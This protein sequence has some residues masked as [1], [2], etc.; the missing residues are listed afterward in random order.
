MQLDPPIPL[1]ESGGVH[2]WEQLSPL[3]VESFT[4]NNMGLTWLFAHSIATI[5]NF[6]A[7]LMRTRCDV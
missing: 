5:A 2:V 1:R 6:V 3:A 4:E 7:R